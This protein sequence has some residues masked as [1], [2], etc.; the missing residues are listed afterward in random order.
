MASKEQTPFPL[1]KATSPISGYYMI[2]CNTSPTSARHVLGQENQVQK[3][4]LIKFVL[5][6]SATSR[7]QRT[8]PHQS[9]GHINHT[10]TKPHPE[11]VIAKLCKWDEAFI[12]HVHIVLK[13]MVSMGNEKMKKLSLRF[14]LRKWGD[15][16]GLQLSTSGV[17]F[18]LW[19]SGWFLPEALYEHLPIT[20]VR[21]RPSW[22][23]GG[24]MPL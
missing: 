13:V 10:H 17:C 6:S 12:F 11:I 21:R 2:R 15:E 23:R 20:A 18:P 14:Y 9:L 7:D 4:L 16:S 1:T 22:N 19:S 5:P 24:A 8:N 3:S